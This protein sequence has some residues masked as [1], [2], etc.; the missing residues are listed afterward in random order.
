MMKRNDFKIL[1]AEDEPEIRKLY[2]KAFQA[3]GYEVV[4][5]STGEQMLAELAESGFDLLI[6]DMQL[7]SMSALEVLP[8]VRKN[9]PK[10]PIVVVSGH[11]TNMAEDFHQK[12]FTVDYFFNKPL[13]LEVLKKTVRTILGIEDAPNNKKKGKSL[14][15]F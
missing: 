6:T 3:E 4:M 11:Y 15:K 8:D 5:A 1:I 13:S 12:G 14:F 9:H 2:A 10:L 7:D